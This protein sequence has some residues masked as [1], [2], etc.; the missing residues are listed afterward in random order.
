M[1]LIFKGI[2]KES[3]LILLDKQLKPRHDSKLKKK[4]KINS[5]NFKQTPM[6][7]IYL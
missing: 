5:N 7:S 2:R 1:N 4:K 6:K 3:Y